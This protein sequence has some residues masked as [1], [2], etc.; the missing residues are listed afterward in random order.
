MDEVEAR[1]RLAEIAE[2]PLDERAGMLEALVGELES[3]LEETSAPD[4]DSQS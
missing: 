1:T 2:L 3:A 4:P